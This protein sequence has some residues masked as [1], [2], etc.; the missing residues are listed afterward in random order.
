MERVTF[1]DPRLRRRLIRDCVLATRDLQPGYRGP[2]P[3]APLERL[4]RALAPGEV[5]ANIAVLLSLPDGR[6]LHVVPGF[7][8][9]ERLEAELD[10]ALRLRDALRGVSRVE[11]E[12]IAVRLHTA[13]ARERPDLRRAHELL[14]RRP[15]V[16]ASAVGPADWADPEVDGAPGPGKFILDLGG[17]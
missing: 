4:G 17:S 3:A 13:R 1:Q 12:R 2:A 11:A 7:S 16:D 5:A 15:L 9:P 6:L 14:V 10:L 8:P